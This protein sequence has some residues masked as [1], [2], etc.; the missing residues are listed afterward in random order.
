MLLG[1]EMVSTGEVACFGENVYEAYLKALMSTGF[2]LPKKNS[3]I[4]LSVGSYKDKVQLLE[5]VKILESLGFS[6]YAS[7]GTADFYS[8]HNVKVQACDW[9]RL[10]DSEGSSS[11]NAASGSP[12]A[13]GDDS[14]AENKNAGNDQRNVADYLMS[15]HF[16]LF[17][18]IPMKAS[19]MGNSFN[20]TLSCL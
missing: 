4:L 15:K 8:E 14:N 17:I 2:R 10:N 1:V 9:K 12:T 7:R 16:D 20:L 13:A 11:N 6:L 5:S 19:G 3:S 18:N